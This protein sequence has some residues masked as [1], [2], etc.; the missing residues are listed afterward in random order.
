VVIFYSRQWNDVNRQILSLNNEIFGDGDT[1][2]PVQ[3]GAIGSFYSRNGGT[4]EF[5]MLAMTKSRQEI[6]LIRGLPG[7]LSIFSLENT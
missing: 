6:T 7:I 5:T 4:K 1:R 3:L 2:S